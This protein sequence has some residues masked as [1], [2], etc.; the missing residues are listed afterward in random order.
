MKCVNGRVIILLIGSILGGIQSSSVAE[1]RALTRPWVPEDLVFEERAGVVA[2]EA[3]HFFQ[4]TAAEKRAWHLHG[5][6][7]E[8]MFDHDA[9]RAHLL[10]ASGGAYLECLP[11]TRHN[12][13]H[14]LIQ[15]ENFINTPGEMA[16]LSY[17]VH[18]NTVGRYYVWVRAYSTGSEDNGIHVG[19][20]GEW[21]ESGQRMQW[22]QGKHSW[23]WESQQRTAENHCGEPYKIFLDIN[24]PGVHTISFSMREDGF[25]FDKFLLTRNREFVRPGD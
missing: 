2:V 18:F 16:V 5:K 6:A 24:R 15:G 10:G 19:L 14:Q 25:E 4:Q 7:V 3:E 11:D 8:P 1:Q 20:N 13:S 12:H 22:C 9:D 21:P 23:R 17:K